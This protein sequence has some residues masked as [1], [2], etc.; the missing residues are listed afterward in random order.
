MADLTFDPHG[1]VHSG[2]PVPAL[3]GFNHVIKTFLSCTEASKTQP[4][5]TLNPRVA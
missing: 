4:F 5:Q 3:P 2:A 1:I